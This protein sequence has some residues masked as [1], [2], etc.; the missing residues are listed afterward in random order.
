VQT[1]ADAGNGF[2][3]AVKFL[4]IVK[5]NERQSVVIRR[6]ANFK[7]ADNTKLFQSRQHA[8]GSKLALWSDEQHGIANMRAH[9][10]RQIDTKHNAEFSGLQIVQIPPFH[11]VG[12]RGEPL[13]RIGQNAAHH[14][15][16][17]AIVQ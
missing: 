6:H 5:V 10:A 3:H 15:A 9:R 7:D 11:F 13:F 8:R 4:R 1:A 2:A 16:F 17:H 14:H 12:K